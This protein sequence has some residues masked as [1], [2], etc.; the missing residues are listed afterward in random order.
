MGSG[1][2][3]RLLLLPA[4]LLRGRDR[5]THV[6]PTTSSGPSQPQTTSTTGP[7]PT[8]SQRNAQLL[9][10]GPSGL[11]SRVVTS[12]PALTRPCLSCYSHNTTHM[13]RWI[14]T[15]AGTDFLGALSSRGGVQ[16]RPTLSLSREHEAQARPPGC[17]GTGSTR[18][19]N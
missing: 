13:C 4:S 3:D 5:S 2:C 18:G 11:A 19:T 9:S 16:G 8:W 12:S 17:F 1:T 7:G 15:S 14:A 6:L 10:A